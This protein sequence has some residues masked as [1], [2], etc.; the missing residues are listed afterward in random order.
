MKRNLITI[1]F[2][3][4]PALI[5]LLTFVI[6][7]FLYT[8]IGSMFHWSGGSAKE[9]VG[10]GNYAKVFTSREIINYANIKEVKGPPFGAFIHNILW[11]IIHV[12]LTTFLGLIIAFLLRGIKGEVI[13]KSF[14]FIGMIVPMVVG[15]VL[16]RFI[17]DKNAG[18]INA[19]LRGLG[20]ENV[21]TWTNYPDTAL[22]AL[23]LGSIWI[24]LGFSLVLYSAG[25]ETIPNEI[26]EAA[27]ID[28]ASNFRIFW[29]IVVPML[30]PITMVVIAMTVIWVLKIFDIVYVTTRGGPGGASSVLALEMYLRAFQY[31]PYDYGTAMAIA[32]ILALLTLGFALYIFKLAVK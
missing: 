21:R 11:I 5:L 2:F 13:I 14:I 8:I 25:L 17:Y 24:W 15:G 26:I 9:F 28:G 27:K 3:L 22:Y 30:K 19:V 31:V 12:P 1:L 10:F 7:P 18:V 6:Y 4:S 32:T 16:L 23:I 29:H 20:F